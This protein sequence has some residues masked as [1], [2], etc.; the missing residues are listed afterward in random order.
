MHAIANE[1]KELAKTINANTLPKGYSKDP[2]FLNVVYNSM[3]VRLT[4]WRRYSAE[5]IGSIIQLVVLIAVF[6]LFATAVGFR[7][8]ADLG[9]HGVYIF[10][11]GAMLI[12]VFDSVAIY[13]PVN[14]MQRDLTNGTLEYLYFTPMNHYGYYLGYII[15]TAI[16]NSLIGF[17]P[18]YIILVWYANLS[19]FNA[20]MIII[21]MFFLIMSLTAMGILISLSVILFKQVQSLLGLIGI[22]M[23][24][25]TGGFIPL[26]SL[27]F[28]I[29]PIAFFFPHTYAYE[30]I[31]YYSFS[32]SWSLM[33]PLVYNWI[34]IVGF[35][36]LYT[37][38]AVVL[39]R[40]V[41]KHAKQKGLHIL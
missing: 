34:L 37:L 25:F 40:K 22:V 18:I 36:I 13:G 27:P 33:L 15:G 16:V 10:F 23:Q 24:F 29:K 14:A 30:L 21:T 6:Y 19:V 28:F 26:V 7:G 41:V 5:A 4:I 35:T 31:H 38:L 8:L 2:S 1:E 20:L 11:L 17:I 9:T 39:L 12:M 3:I 32:G